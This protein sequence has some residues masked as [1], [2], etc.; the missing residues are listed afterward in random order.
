MDARQMAAM[1]EATRLTRQGRLVEATTLIQRTLA[2]P[3]VTRRAPDAS[4]AEGGTGSA[5]G[6]YS[7]P[8]PALLARVGTKLS[9]SRSGWIPRLRTLPGRGA[10]GPHRRR[11]PAVPAVSPPDGRFDA[12]SYTNAAGTRAYR[13]YIPASHAGGP[14]PLVVMLHGGTQDAATFAAATGMNDLAER[15]CSG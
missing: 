12:F 14:L 6:R 4:C 10:S 13:L 8:P 15:A 3:E 1:A 11:Q 2:N 7:D 5:P 9:E